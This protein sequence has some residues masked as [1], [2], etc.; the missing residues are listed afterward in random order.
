MF[1][2]YLLLHPEDAK[3]GF[4]QQVVSVNNLPHPNST[5]NIVDKDYLEK[6]KQLA[7]TGKF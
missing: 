5:I 1:Y 4:I 6:L 7:I 3:Y 2:S